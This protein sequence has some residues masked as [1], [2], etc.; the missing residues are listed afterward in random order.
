MI[1]VYL[2]PLRGS[3]GEGGQHL[4][5]KNYRCCRLFL[6]GGRVV[7]FMQLDHEI[8]KR[9]SVGIPVAVLIAEIQVVSQ[10]FPVIVLKR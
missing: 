8:L 6:H 7:L 3:E 4:I 5:I 10:S 9:F 1:L 2:T